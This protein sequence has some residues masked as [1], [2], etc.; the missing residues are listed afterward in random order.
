MTITDTRPED[1]PS[2]DAAASAAASP[3]DSPGAATPPEAKGLVAWLTTGDHKKVGRLFIGA[4]FVYV[5]AALVVASLLGIERID[6]DGTQ[7]L[8]LNSVTQLY[9]LYAIGVAFLFAVPLFLGIAIC[10]VP[11]QVGARTLAF[12]RAAA[13][14]FWGWLVASG[15]MIAAYAMNG[16]PGGGDA[17]GVD[18]FLL[19]FIAVV[20]SLLLAAICVGA[21]VLALRAPGMTTDRTPFASWGFMVGALM[22]LLT[23]P[24]LIANLL[25]MWVDHRYGRLGFG[26]NQGIGP[27]IA[28]TVTQPQIY[29]YALPALAVFAEVAPIFARRRPQPPSG[30]ITVSALTAVGVLGFGAFAQPVL[31]PQVTERVFYKAMVIAVVV[32]ILIVLLNSLRVIKGRPQLRS[33]LLFALA[34]TLVLLAGAAAGALSTFD[35]LEL[36]G[37]TWQQGQFELVVLGGGLLGGLAAL[38]LWGPKIWGRLLS[39]LAASALAVL[40]TLTL[41]LMAG[42]NLAA[43]LLDQP[44]GEVNFV[45]E[46]GTGFFNVCVATGAIALTILAIAAVLLLHR[47]FT[48]GELA[49][50]DPWE[51]HTLEWA[52]PSPPPHGNFT[53]PLPPIE[54][55]RPLLDAREAAAAAKEA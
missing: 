37:T 41:L 17:K 13:A 18:L 31:Y 55:D 40:M 3:P 25:Y 49:G 7:I 44:A 47:G 9:S 50:E 43:G 51:G 8:K 36:I 20:L 4:A 14:S 6:S 42:G 39:D 15:V 11:L 34:A 35:D 23:L 38:A 22:L 5:I 16:G 45:G 2:S 26:G 1:A 46:G 53:A 52:T 12:P 27:R 24:V 21:T 10:V 33:P 54:T 30:T 32:P 29:I 28:W 48:K 19:S